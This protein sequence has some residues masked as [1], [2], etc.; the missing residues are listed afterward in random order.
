MA[1]VTIHD[2]TSVQIELYATRFAQKPQI[3]AA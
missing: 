1:N 3:N 2:V